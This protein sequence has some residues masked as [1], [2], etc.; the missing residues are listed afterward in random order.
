[1]LANK[2]VNDHVTMGEESEDENVQAGWKFGKHEVVTSC[3]ELA[4]FFC[5]FDEYRRPCSS[6]AYIQSDSCA[7][8]AKALHR[9]VWRNGTNLARS[10][11]ITTWTCAEECG[12]TPSC[13]HWVHNSTNGSDC[14]SRAVHGQQDSKSEFSKASCHKMIMK[15][16]YHFHWKKTTVSGDGCEAIEVTDGNTQSLYK[17][18]VGRD[19]VLRGTNTSGIFYG[20]NHSQKAD[21][22]VGTGNYRF[23]LSDDGLT[24]SGFASSCV[25]LSLYMQRVFG[26]FF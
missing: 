17:S 23:N 6:Y 21:N 14:L 22:C 13:N 18:W 2:C 25:F 24:L 11:N 20:V 3:A 1:M 12:A 19:V 4:S 15:G 10:K 7:A 16:T 26:L 9:V 8:D 5:T